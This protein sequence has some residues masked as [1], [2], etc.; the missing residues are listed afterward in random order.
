MM[1]SNSNL[2][3]RFLALGLLLLGFAL[4]GAI[5]AVPHIRLASIETQIA[6]K[7]P[8]LSKLRAN[9]ARHP[10]LKQENQQLL[11]SDKKTKLLLPG[12]VTGVAGANLQK[13]LVD[14]VKKHGGQANS[15][16]VLPPEEE[17]NLIKISMSLALRVNTTGLRNILFALETSTPLIFVDDITINANR[18]AIARPGQITLLSVNMQ[19]SGFIARK[20][21]S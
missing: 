21:K 5:A 16:Q 11:S 9:L 20:G 12:A 14:L 15:F 4:L 19:V 6:S 2:S 13:L 17:S 10:Q 8:I 18:F 3:T 7:R 1:I